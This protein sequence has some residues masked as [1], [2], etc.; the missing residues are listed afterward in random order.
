MRPVTLVVLTLAAAGPAALALSPASDSLVSH[1]APCSLAASAPRLVESYD[2]ARQSLSS[3]G[4]HMSRISGPVL[5]AAIRF[6][7]WKGRQQGSRPV[8]ERISA[9]L[10]PHFPPGML[11]QVRWVSLD[12]ELRGIRLDEGCIGVEGAMTLGDTIVFSSAQAATSVELWAHELTHVEQYSR[13]GLDRFA[14][15]YA[16][17]RSRLEREAES[18]GARVAEQ[19]ARAH[20]SVRPRWADAFS[21]SRA[22]ATNVPW[23]SRQLP[24]G[25]S[26]NAQA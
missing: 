20:A 1:F 22:R 26:S 25:I 17:D 11:G 16:A 10:G 23:P 7:R 6:S 12:R 15:A 8:P 9:A 19:V 4:L 21:L 14:R 18:N 5:A 13:L 3:T 2:G 24:R